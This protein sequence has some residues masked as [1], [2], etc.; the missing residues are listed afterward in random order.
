M[1]L[2]FAFPAQ[3]PAWFPGHMAKSL[4]IMEAKMADTHLFV[5]VRDARLPLTSIN[6]VFQRFARRE[7]GL[8]RLIVYC[9]RDLGDVRF[10]KVR[11]LRTSVEA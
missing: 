10:E 7:Q 4:R 6:P 2:K 8:Q 3:L 11:T 5:E 9:R 1:N